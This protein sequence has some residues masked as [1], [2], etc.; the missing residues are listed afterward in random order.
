MVGSLTRPH[1]QIDVRDMVGSLTRSHCITGYL[2]LEIKY[3]HT[4]FLKYRDSFLP[5]CDFHECVANNK[6]IKI[7]NVAKIKVKW[8][9]LKY[10]AKNKCTAITNAWTIKPRLS[11]N[12]LQSMCKLAIGLV[13]TL[14]IRLVTTLLCAYCNVS[15]DGLSN[16]FS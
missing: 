11:L 15:V 3:D 1:R 13:T 9:H 7:C 12:V 16:L 10:V 4:S 14:V 8:Y 6:Y 5:Y 2:H